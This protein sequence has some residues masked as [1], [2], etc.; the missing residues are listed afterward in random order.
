[1]KGD[2]ALLP[3]ELRSAERFDGEN[4]EIGEDWDGQE[5][6]LLSVNYSWK[7]PLRMAAIPF[8]IRLSVSSLE[9]QTRLYHRRGSEKRPSIVAR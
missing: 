4:D 8:P 2:D 7:I 5:R 3:L 1:M 6:T 9:L